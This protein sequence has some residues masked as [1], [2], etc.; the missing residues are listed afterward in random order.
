MRRS[1]WPLVVLA[2]LL[3]GVFVRLGFWQISRLHERRARNAELSARLAAPP[4][5]L[6][7]LSDT[8]SYKRSTVTG[9]P[10]YTNEVLYTGRS[11]DGSPGVYVLTPLVTKPNA[12]AVLVIRGWVYAPDAATIDLSKWHEDRQSYTG[13]IAALPHNPAP[14]PPKERKVRTLDRK[15]LQG[16]FPYMLSPMYL[17]AQD[18]AGPNAPIRLPPPRLD[19]GPHLSYAIQWFAFAAIALAGAVVVARRT[20]SQSD[21]PT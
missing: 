18:S 5:S 1:T 9:V 19:D 21:Q 7:S 6:D 11:H 14:A 2:V 10:D 17:V 15:S 16:L 20:Q 13:Y 4:V 8:L 12:R 3:A